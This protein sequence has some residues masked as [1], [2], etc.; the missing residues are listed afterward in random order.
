MPPRRDFDDET[1]HLRDLNLFTRGLSGFVPKAV[2][3]RAVSITVETDQEQYDGE[4]TVEMTIRISNSLP[5]PVEI[6]TTGQRVWGWRVDGLL[7]ASDEKLYER[8]EPRAFSFQSRETLTIQREWDFRF[9]RDGTP[10]RWERAGRGEHEIEA[11]LAT[12]PEKTDSTTI[13]LR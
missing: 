12:N 6:V 13:E 10:T 3:T 8:Q 5:V 7:A 1:L 4:S 9:K 2:A 11:F